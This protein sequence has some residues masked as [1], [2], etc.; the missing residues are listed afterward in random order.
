VD[1]KVSVIIPYYNA[2]KYLEAAV[3][4]VLEQTYR[5]YELILIDDGSADESSGVI[6]NINDSRI[7]LYRNEKNIGIPAA[8]NQG[9]QYAKGKYIAWLDSDD[10][11]LPDRI[12]KQVLLFDKN[13]K[14]GLCGTSVQTLGA[15][16]DMEWCYPYSSELL[17]CRMLLDNPF[18]TSSIMM[19]AEALRKGSFKFDTKF[20]VAEDY[21]LWEK[22]SRDWETTNIQEILT[23]YRIHQTQSSLGHDKKKISRDNVWNIQSRLLNGLGIAASEEEKNLHLEI[24]VGWRFPTTAEGFDSVGKWLRKL[25]KANVE[26]RCFDPHKLKDVLAERW[27]QAVLRTPV[28]QGILGKIQFFSRKQNWLYGRAYFLNSFKIEYA[29]LITHF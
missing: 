17:R 5:D 24:G 12:Q 7:R 13:P 4:S 11:S 1:P 25:L 9:I 19:R 22:I 18:A 21:D 6:R 8:R 28:P 23:R 20:S 2:A 16:V 3:R 15:P 29:S 26:H 10:L 27:M 14:L